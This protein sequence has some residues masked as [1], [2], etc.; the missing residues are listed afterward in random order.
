M[1]GSDCLRCRSIMICED[2]RD[3]DN[4]DGDDNPDDAYHD[5]D[6]DAHDDGDVYN[7]RIRMSGGYCIRFRLSMN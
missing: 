4:N 3:D 2:D 6:G 1:R 5:A 7:K